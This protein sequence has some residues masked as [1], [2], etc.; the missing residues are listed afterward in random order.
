MKQIKAKVVIDRYAGVTMGSVRRLLKRANVK[1]ASRGYDV[2]IIVGGDG[3]F[4][5]QSVRHLNVPIIPV[6]KVIARP[7]GGD[8][9]RK[10]RLRELP[11]VMGRMASGDYKVISE[12]LL[13]A[14]YGGRRYL[15]AGDFYVERG[16]IKHAIRYS[17]SIREGGRTIR[18]SAV[19]NGFVVTTPIGS[20]GYY[21]YV[22]ML[23]RRQARRIR[24]MGFAH[25]LPANVNDTI[26]GAVVGY[27]VRRSMLPTTR[28]TVV[29]RR[30]SDQYLY[31]IP[32]RRRG[33]RI[34]HGKKISFRLLRDRLRI[35]SV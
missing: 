33:L 18:T 2:A 26:N 15:S 32:S 11:S 28:I 14:E 6:M 12:P 20:T 4:L 27:K 9:I 30:G 8:K 13:E 29:M 24:G 17:A 10:Y 31:G 7:E 23:A 35:I 1:V 25:I 3:T 34:G 5:K 21:A 16:N 19:S 22:E